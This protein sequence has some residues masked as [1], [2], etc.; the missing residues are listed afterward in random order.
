MPE[1][2][3]IHDL[4]RRFQPLVGHRFTVAKAGEGRWRRGDPA[5]LVG[6]TITKIEARGKH[7]LFFT[8]ERWVL[9][10][11]LGLH[12]DWGQRGGPPGDRTLELRIDTT[13][14]FLHKG[15][16]A[17]L[18]RE[19]DLPRHPVLSRL[20]PDVLADDFDPALAARRAAALPEIQLGDLILDQSVACGPGNVYKSEALFVLSLHPFTPT[21]ALPPEGL[22]ALYRELQ[23]M[24]R[25]NLGRPQRVTTTG[26]AR[27]GGPA[28]VYD[29]TGRPCLRCGTPIESRRQGSDARMTY[30]CPRCQPA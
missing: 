21:R 7:L 1:G 20:G 19:A 11:H 10:T 25:R 29:R 15:M 6:A 12:G 4:A 23:A 13:A 24:M 18:L 26:T 30:W 28:W 9:W 5:R 8:A 14:L 27:K 17:S 16:E 3:N 22:E 2:D